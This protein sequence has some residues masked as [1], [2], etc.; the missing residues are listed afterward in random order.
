MAATISILKIPEGLPQWNLVADFLKLRRRVFMDQMSWELIETGGMEYE[1]YDT[2]EAVY[3]LVHDQGTL[4]GG[5]RLLRTTHRVG[6]GRHTY[7][8]MIRD[9]R[10]GLLPGLPS[11]LCDEEPPVDPA[12]WELTRFAA[13]SSVGLGADILNAVN[14]FLKSAGATSCLFLGPPAFMRMAKSMGYSPKAMG[15]IVGNKDGRFLAFACAVV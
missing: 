7:S 14:S 13:P 1:Q 3:V 15:K 12:I 8:Y 6:V 5:A 2:L 9:A 4:L 10:L 11:D